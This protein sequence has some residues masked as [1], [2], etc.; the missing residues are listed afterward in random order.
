MSQ[1]ITN[2]RA[3]YSH[4]TPLW[5][6]LQRTFL[7]PLHPSGQLRPSTVILT[8]ADLCSFLLLNDLPINCIGNGANAVTASAALTQMNGFWKSSPVSPWGSPG[9]SAWVS[10][11]HKDVNL[12]P[13]TDW[14][15]R[16]HQLPE[17]RDG[18]KPVSNGR[19]LSTRTKR[20]LERSFYNFI[21]EF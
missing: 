17:N 8:R 9:P 16:Q 1:G 14:L 2:H 13:S 12:S 15:Q 5:Q 7:V 11:K 20:P 10:L 4:L 18:N 19:D 6:S 21:L 3:D